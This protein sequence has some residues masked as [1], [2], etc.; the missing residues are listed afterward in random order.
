MSINPD[1]APAY[2]QA[3][4]TAYLI[5]PGG[6]YSPVGAIAATAG[7]AGTDHGG[8]ASAPTLAAA[9]ASIPVAGATSAAAEV[10]DPAGAYS[11]AAATTRTTDPAGTDGGASAPALA[12]AGASIPITG[13]TSAAAE[14]VG[15]A[16]TDGG[17][18]APTIDLAGRRSAAGVSAPTFAAPGTYIPV[19]GATSSA[20]ENVDPAG[21]YSLAGV[22]AAMIDP[23][24]RRSAAGVSAPTLAA[25]GAR[26][27]ATEATSA[28]AKIVS[29]PGT[30][31][32]PGATAPISDPG[33]T[34]SAAGASAPTTDPAG[35]YSSPY[36]LDRLVI[37]WEQNT[38][39]NTVLSFS[40]ATAVANYYGGTSSEASLAKEFF[41]GYAGVAGVTLSF[42]RYANGQRPHLLGA[43]ISSL[44]L[45]QLQAISGPISL[46]FD[47]FTYNGNVNLKGVASFADA[48]LKI[49][50][51]LN[52]SAPTAAVTTGSSIK[53]E[54]VSF[55]GY[56]GEKGDTNHL[57][58]TSVSSG[59]I[60][61]GG[62]VSGHGLAAGM[63]I[64]GQ[65]NGTPGGAGEYDFFAGSGEVSTAEAM[66][67]TY[68]LL[69]VGSVTSGNVALGERITG[70]G[71]PP[72]T[73]IDTNVS[74]S[75]AGSQWIVNNALNLTG[76]IIMTA[77]TFTV[78]A[79]SSFVGAT[80]TDAYF[81]IQPNGVFGFDNNPSSLS[82]MS[83]SKA[84]TELGLTKAS[85]A[86]NSSPGGIHE[87]IATYMNNVLTETNQF[88]QP[89]HFGSFQS[90]EPRL[91]AGLAAWA[92]SPDGYG[93][94]FLASIFN[95]PPAG[96]STPVIDP[97][98][99]YSPADASAPT[100]GPGNLPSVQSE[101][102]FNA[103]IDAV[104]T[105]TAIQ[106]EAITYENNVW[107]GDALLK[108]VTPYG[109][110]VEFWI[111]GQTLQFNVQVGPATSTI[112]TKATQSESTLQTEINAAEPNKAVAQ[113]A[114]NDTLLAYPGGLGLGA[115][116]ETSGNTTWVSVY[117]QE[118]T[119]VMMVHPK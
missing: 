67:E 99:S 12:A 61:I 86:I 70:E 77:P 31:L 45:A 111:E 105:S 93:Y 106:N 29:P 42:T 76:N 15:P 50:D 79:Q 80:K 44:P 98:G 59:A 16:G 27:P 19:A 96:S 87:S 64:V 92:Q 107:A 53:S 14:I 25:P 89:V 1:A 21:A 40:S 24:G 104:N 41:A 56:T 119:T 35:T 3:G 117:E 22:S 113:A 54:S 110:G 17:P 28:A 83:P 116:V 11:P 36:A 33:G 8:R 85:G 71:V 94:Q 55:T 88:G 73:A 68:G 26:I 10:V 51:A 6:A 81:E 72:L 108:Y 23:A 75:G 97:A 5:V 65:L 66:K 43:N 48:A 37:L 7:P 38:P 103:A 57:Y 100:L 112:P 9:G 118:S 4:A 78:E 62:I 32:P 47:G 34:Y 69:T 115:T 39:A 49:R 102:T 18:S 60:Q 13:A 114:Y 91:D 90:V 52:G 109:Q 63:Q 74:G 82:Y 101:P 20:A 2:S 30:Y 95:T 46:T 58:V 84:A